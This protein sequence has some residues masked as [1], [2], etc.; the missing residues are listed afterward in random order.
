MGVTPAPFKVARP[1]AY[2]LQAQRDWLR[3]K[4]IRGYFL[5][6]HIYAIPRQQATV[7]FN[8]VDSMTMV[9]AESRRW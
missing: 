3:P 1:D 7:A 2:G 8:L 9:I 5:L 4:P 6:D